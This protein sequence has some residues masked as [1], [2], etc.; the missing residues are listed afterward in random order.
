VVGTIGDL[1]KGI[2]L[3]PSDVVDR[4]RATAADIDVASLQRLVSAGVR[5]AIPTPEQTPN[6][7]ANAL[8]RLGL[9]SGR[10]AIRLTVPPSAEVLQRLQTLG[11]ATLGEPR[12]GT[13]TVFIVVVTDPL[14]IAEQLRANAVPGVDDVE[15]EVIQPVIVPALVPSRALAVAPDYWN[16]ISRLKGVDGD[17]STIGVFDAGFEAHHRNLTN[18][19][20]VSSARV[21]KLDGA[22]PRLVAGIEPDASSSHGVACAS[23]IAGYEDQ[24]QGTPGVASGARMIPISM[25]VTSSQM[26]FAE[27]IE[28]LVNSGADAIVGSIHL[29]DDFNGTSLTLDTATRMAEGRGSCVVWAALEKPARRTEHWIGRFATVSLV[30]A[31][32]TNYV[33]QDGTWDVDCVAPGFDLPVAMRRNGFSNV[34]ATLGGHSLATPIVAAT[35]A[36]VKRTN[37]GLT[38][39]Q[40]RDSVARTCCASPAS[41]GSAAAAYG[42]GIVNVARAC[43]VAAGQSWPNCPAFT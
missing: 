34:S 21:A 25:K 32:D 43:A 6:V 10:L 35:L 41:T 13:Q 38:A 7:V 22:V 1:L 31:I 3:T 24:G 12:F 2:P 29:Q 4:M 18:A 39:Q 8:G 28:H 40:C 27:G 23:L 37:R 11:I 5:F 17:G 15:V 33:R 14:G 36:L 20:L 30:A 19:W 9:M 42:A 16:V 26:L